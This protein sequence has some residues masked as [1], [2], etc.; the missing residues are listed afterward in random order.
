M[1]EN[2]PVCTKSPEKGRRHAAQSGRLSRLDAEIQGSKS[3][4][5]WI[6]WSN[7]RWTKNLVHNKIDDDAWRYRSLD[8]ELKACNSAMG[9]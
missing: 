2:E 5:F 6:G 4:K 1:N 3:S 8:D 7:V 9:A